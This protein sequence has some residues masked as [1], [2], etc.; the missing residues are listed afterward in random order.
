LESDNVREF[1]T[2]DFLLLRCQ[3]VVRGQI[4]DIEP[5][6]GGASFPAHVLPL[7]D[8]AT[9]LGAT[10]LLSRDTLEE[11]FRGVAVTY[12][13]RLGS[14]RAEDGG[15]IR[16]GIIG[17]ETDAWCHV[18]ADRYPQL[19]VA[20]AG[21]PVSI[22]GYFGGSMIGGFWIDAAELTFG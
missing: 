1:R 3:I 5:L 22:I 2:P 15:V 7:R 17:P 6:V 9:E 13:G 8:L 16:V 19:A 10:P 12:S 4:L 14:L 18:D 11:T 21:V 20:K